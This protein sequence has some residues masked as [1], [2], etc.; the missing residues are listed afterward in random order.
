MKLLLS[1]LD[2]FNNEFYL[3]KQICGRWN[4]NQSTHEIAKQFNY[5][6]PDMAFCESVG[7]QQVI[8]DNLQN[9]GIP[10]QKFVDNRKKE[11][12]LLEI[13]P[14]LEQGRI[15]FKTGEDWDILKHQ[16]RSYPLSPHDDRH[17]SLWMCISKAGAGSCFTE[18]NIGY[19]GYSILL[20]KRGNREAEACFMLKISINRPV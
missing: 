15:H 10:I 8:V 6:H 18:S 3:E 20:R 4:S 17:E 7:F 1:I 12:K 11:V 14:F 5:W 9:M 13:L 2:V 19:Y 16:V